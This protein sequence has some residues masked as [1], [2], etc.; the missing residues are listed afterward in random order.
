MLAVGAKFARG[1]GGE[2]KDEEVAKSL[3]KLTRHMQAILSKLVA[4]QTAKKFQQRTNEPYMR[5]RTKQLGLDG[6]P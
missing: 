4:Y 1:R 5:R 2:G 6:E 3:T